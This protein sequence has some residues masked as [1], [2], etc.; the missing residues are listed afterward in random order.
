MEPEKILAYLLELRNYTLLERYVS[1]LLTEYD[2]KYIVELIRQA[3][4][5]K[6]LLPDQGNP[7]RQSVVNDGL[8]NLVHLNEL[9]GID[10][11]YLEAFSDLK[12]MTLDEIRAE[13]WEHAK[14][15]LSEQLKFGITFFLDVEAMRQKA[16]L[17]PF[18]P[19][20]LNARISEVQ[21]L[22]S[23]PPLSDVYST[24][25]GFS[26]ITSG[27]V[28]ANQSGL[29]AE[30]R[31]KIIE[32]LREIGFVTNLTAKQLKYSPLAF[33]GCSP[34]LKILLWSL[35]WFCIGGKK[36]WNQSMKRLVELGDSRALPFIESAI[37]RYPQGTLVQRNPSLLDLLACIG[38]ISSERLAY[39][40]DD[41]FLMKTHRYPRLSNIVRRRRIM[42][43]TVDDALLGY[44]P[45][46][47][48]MTI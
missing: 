45:D 32:S 30:L 42:Q 8:V 22:E 46:N 39:Y 9:Y 41:Y 44:G 17:L 14:D 4:A 13:A 23:H 26:I 48:R 24:Y 6:E 25:Y 36:R 31:Q 11:D 12:G 37:M 21:G 20:T 7:L 40:T 15:L 10:V 3:K 16:D 35:L 19:D 29:S 18:I 38:K 27:G 28:M 33:R 2:W 47:F 43:K 5:I 34:S 1:T